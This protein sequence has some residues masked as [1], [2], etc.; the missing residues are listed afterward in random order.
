MKQ[1]SKEEDQCINELHAA[2]NE[3]D[4]S[5]KIGVHLILIQLIFIY[6][7]GGT[8]QCAPITDKFLSQ[9]N[10]SLIKVLLENNMKIF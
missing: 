4:N 7:Y 1:Y 3:G 5:R 2:E 9:T 10:E 8:F 6:S